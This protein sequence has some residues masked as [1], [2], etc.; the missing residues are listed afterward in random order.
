VRKI[1]VA[2]AKGGT[3][4]STTAV[5]L[6][7]GLARRGQRV[8]L[9][10]ADTQGQVATMLGQDTTAGLADL[11]DDANGDPQACLHEARDNLW[12]L[13]GGGA[14]ASVER[15][16]A[17][18]EF[19]GEQSLARALASVDGTFDLAI[20][21]TAP[22]WA[23][24]TINALFYVEEIVAAVSLEALSLHGLL[25]FQQRIE[26]IRQYHPR[27]CLSYL[28][29]TFLDGRVRKSAELLEQLR[30]R[31]GDTCCDPIRYNVRL[32]E[33]PGF[34]QSIYEYSPRSTGARDYE[35]L[36]ERVFYG[37]P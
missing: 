16:I 1:G 5:N 32:S 6:A 2:L 18:R 22:G 28:L 3:G 27:L 12:L 17:G 20:V 14:L 7:T 37:A 9:I 15:T 26:A 8:L 13:A 36:V 23:P 30:E 21:D 25:A 33:A 4:K 34:G 24:L 31:F 10:D 11:F 35:K 19:G 29:P